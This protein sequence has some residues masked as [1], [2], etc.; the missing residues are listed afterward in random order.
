MLPT[1]F[2]DTP[3][4]PFPLELLANLTLHPL[5]PVKYQPPLALTLPV[6]RASDLALVE[7]A[8]VAAVWACAGWVA[9]KA[10]RAFRFSGPAKKV[11]AP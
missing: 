3:P 11:K 1:F 6:G 7:L 10:W 8:T 9:Y 5:K 4:S 2:A